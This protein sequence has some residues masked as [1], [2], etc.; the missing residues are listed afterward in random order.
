MRKIK[1]CF[2]L[3]S[4]SFGILSITHTA[5]AQ[6]AE[7]KDTYTGIITADAVNVRSGPSLNHEIIT[8]LDKDFLVLVEDQTAEWIKIKL[9]PSSKAYVYKNFVLKDSSGNITISG[10]RVNIRAEK[11]TNSNIVGQL[12]T[13]DP[14]ELI[15]TE[16]DWYWIFPL[17]NCVAWVNKNYVVK[18]GKPELY[19]EE[20]N[21]Y[22]L[23]ISSFPR[24]KEEKK[25][26]S[27]AA[28]P[29]NI[30]DIPKKQELSVVNYSNVPPTVKGKVMDMGRV[31]QR[32][33][34]HKLLADKKL[35]YYL[36]SD[37]INLN[38]FIYHKVNIW[39]NITNHKKSK[40]PIIEVK[41][42]QKLN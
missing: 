27:P 37:D 39:G 18:F 2:F 40:I 13:G 41:H 34:T 23:K 28:V 8:K 10:N 9:P 31:L 29:E 33:G 20:E 4:I 38:D 11:G 19:Y 21:K 25:T 36:K 17:K 35:V 30:T 7:A 3:I 32:Q 1:T 16:G 14:I 12:N 5:F 42:I 26:I 24:L 22:R 15:N 6:S